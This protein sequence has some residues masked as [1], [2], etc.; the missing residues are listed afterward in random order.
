MKSHTAPNT[1]REE[2]LNNEGDDILEEVV[3]TR[4]GWITKL[5]HAAEEGQ[6]PG[7]F[8]QLMVT[9]VSREMGTNRSGAAWDTIRI[10]KI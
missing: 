9:A 2:Y 3:S 4:R 7:N 5:T 1:S 6:L 10:G 8:N